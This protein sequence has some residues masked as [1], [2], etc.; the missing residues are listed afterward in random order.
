MF[1]RMLVLMMLVGCGSSAVVQPSPTIPAVA[2]V[3]QATPAIVPG[4][5]TMVA[6]PTTQ[7]SPTV[8]VPTPA[9]RPR[10]G[11]QVGHWRTEE[12]P[13]ELERF[14]TSTGAFADG[15]S[16]VEV[17]LP[18]AQ[19]VIELLQA[20]GIEAE[21]LPATVPISYDADVFITIHADGSPSSSKGGFKMAT[22]WRTSDASQHLLEALDSEYAA[23]TGF[24]RDSAVT[25]NMRG[26]YAFSWW[27]RQHAIAKTTPA[28]IIEMGFLTNP[29]ERAL[30]LHSPDSVC[31]KH[32]RGCAT[33][34]QRARSI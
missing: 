10:V 19:R 30:M 29:T 34:P 20:Q 5:P 18:I 26:Y 24:T 12:L 7:P 8:A 4:T 27:R 14:R 9:P 22:P 13:D 25:F 21:L 15:V 23:G 2:P 33:L 31:A 28:V 17:N 32:R 11:V 6:T 3:A 1:K 16:E